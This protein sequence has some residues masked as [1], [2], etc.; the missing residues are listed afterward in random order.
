MRQGI[1]V[2][3]QL[4]RV[5]RE[6]PGRTLD[7]V[8]LVVVSAE[9]RPSAVEAA[10]VMHRNVRLQRPGRRKDVDLVDTVVDQVAELHATRTP[11]ARHPGRSERADVE[12]DT[13]Y[14]P[15]GMVW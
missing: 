9:R 14:P 7:L 5:R 6:R 2:D 15:C 11:C 10:G 8:Q 3:P 4:I 1:E 12:R 13:T